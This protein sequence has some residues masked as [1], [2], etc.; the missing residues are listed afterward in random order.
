MNNDKRRMYMKRL[1]YGIFALL[2]ALSG[3]LPAMSKASASTTNNPVELTSGVYHNGDSNGFTTT[4][5]RSALPEEAK[6][7]TYISVSTYI[8][9]KP[10]VTPNNITDLMS[11]NA[12]YTPAG[13]GS[14]L[15]SNANGSTAYALTIL[16]VEQN[17]DIN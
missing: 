2:L 14:G 17:V 3:F 12:L 1:V 9:W 4:I 7:F 5:D 16:Y 15:P 6:N 8:G 11:S 10:V 13:Y